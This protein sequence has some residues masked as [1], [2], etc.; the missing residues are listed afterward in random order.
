[1]TLTLADLLGYRSTAPLAGRTDRPPADVPVSDRELP[2]AAA[3]PVVEGPTPSLRV[4][5]THDSADSDPADD[6]SDDKG[7]DLNLLAIYQAQAG[8]LPLLTAHQEVELSRRVHAGLAAKAR[9]DEGTTPTHLLPADHAAVADGHAARNLLIEHNLRLV[10]HIAIR[11]R[12]TVSMDTL[13][14]VQAGNEGLIR[15]AEK[16]DGSLGNRFSTYATW[17]IRQSISRTC[18][19][20]DRTIRIPVHRVEVN[21]RVRAAALA[22]A[23]ARPDGVADLAAVAAHLGSTIAEVRTSLLELDQTVSLEH[24]TGLPDAPTVL[25][26]LAG[27]PQEDPGPDEL[28]FAA[29]I[30]DE[31]DRVLTGLGQRPRSVLRARHGLDGDEQQTLEQISKP[32]GITRE[33]VRQI[34]AKAAEELR[35]THGS[36]LSALLIIGDPWRDEDHA[37]FTTAAEDAAWRRYLVRAHEALSRTRTRPRPGGPHDDIEHL[38]CYSYT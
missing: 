21:R 4:A 25:D 37:R 2:E 13:D 35:G 3:V 11:H 16:F 32:L 8:R 31:I 30:A 9:L 29:L 7:K 12:R 10:V 14:L 17:W 1:M 34:E 27:L 23:G 20:V 38:G 24:P 22:D 28:A 19:D 36:H 18:D 5:G 15:A 33:R 26:V 6:D